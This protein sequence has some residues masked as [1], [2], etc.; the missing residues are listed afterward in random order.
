[1]L[2]EYN[3]YDHLPVGVFVIDSMRKVVS[4]NRT[5]ESWTGIK[6][7]EIMGTAIEET[8][9]VLAHPKYA[10]RIEQVF[11]SGPPTVFSAQLHKSILVELPRC[12][13]RYHITTVSRLKEGAGSSTTARVLFN[14]Q[15][16]TDLVR[17]N[18]QYS[19][20]RKELKAQM[21][22]QLDLEGRLMEAHK[23]EAISKLASSFA[24]YINNRLQV[25]ANNVELA[26]MKIAAGLPG[27]EKYLEKVQGETL[28]T[29]KITSTFL[30]IGRPKGDL[31]TFNM[32][33]M[34][35]GLVEKL[36]KDSLNSRRID[37]PSANRNVM[38]RGDPKGLSR[39]I[40]EIL[41]NACYATRDGGGI[42]IDIT[43]QG[44][45]MPSGDAGH[46]ADVDPFC[47]IVIKDSGEGL[48]PALTHKVF[49]PFFQYNLDGEHSGIGLTIANAI[50]Q[51][52][53]GGIDFRSEKE[54][55]TEVT[56]SLPMMV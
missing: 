18:I 40:E 47:R 34:V 11:Q 56:V 46:T 21:A 52:H 8:L 20:T 36:N 44:G 27:L 41:K 9:S 12:R 50:I 3:L 19:E 4:W 7:E 35:R 30:D 14:L 5:M 55:G 1:M 29:K 15:D 43:A 23:M 45:A 28:R 22:K 53:N 26:Q 48:D 49:E 17:R 2:S 39:A 31:S 51:A 24:H 13:E 38:V 6:T 37:L 42:A 10:T 54:V 33:A 32:D 25:I 16:V